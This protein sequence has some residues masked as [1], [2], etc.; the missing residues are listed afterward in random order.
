MA[1]N[2]NRNRY[3]EG[4]PD[5]LDAFRQLPDP[6]QSPATRH[7]F[8][9]ILFI[10]LA[11]TISG[12]DGFEDITV[13]SRER[14]D[15]LR[16]HLE[17]PNGL[18]SAD[19]YARVFAAIDPQAFVEC[20]IGLV[21][22]R[23]PALAGELIAIDG[24]TLRRSGTKGGRK[25][26]HVISA[27]AG[28]RGITLGQLAV[29]EKSNE[30]T[31]VPKLLAQ[32]D[33]KGCVVSLD[34][35]GCQHRTAVAIAHAGADWLLALKGNQGTLHEG[36]V[37]LF[38]D[39]EALDWIE[40]GRGAVTRHAEIDAGHGRVEERRIC[41]TDHL[42]WIAP[43]ERIRWMGIRSVMCVESVRLLPGEEAV[44]AKRY[45]L[46]SLP[47]DATR[48]L[49]LV[50][51]H[52]AIEN[53]CHWVMDVVFNEDQSRV[54]NGHAAKNMSLLRRLSHN[55]L[56]TSG[57]LAGKSVRSKR[58]AAGLNPTRLAAFLGLT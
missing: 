7:Y 10:A 52:W 32:L 31:A 9:E 21:S 28:S 42:D 6:R 8:G 12:M 17:L 54:R 14:E 3:R 49:A 22:S 58:L 35:M 29:A 57:E 11:A 41:V 15:W 37:S 18:P 16:G 51:G 27:W 44:M 53:R 45:W 55:L 43:K 2:N 25:A 30:I 48:L 38:S 47:P 5:C 36:A 26:L 24:K 23:S 40:A 33:V 13:F 34:A 20:F 39:G 50:R 1:W 46:S 19:T 56:Q 4:F